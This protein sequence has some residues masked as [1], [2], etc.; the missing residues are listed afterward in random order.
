M[1]QLISACTVGVKAVFGEECE[2]TGAMTAPVVGSWGAPAWTAK[3]P[4]R[5]S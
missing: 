1:G 2:L 5:R 3:V 4:K